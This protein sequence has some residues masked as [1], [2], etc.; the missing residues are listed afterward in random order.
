MPH[1]RVTYD[2][3]MSVS[4]ALD[5]PDED[6]AIEAAAGHAAEYLNAL[7][8]RSIGDARVGA[9]ADIDGLESRVEEI[10]P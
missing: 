4:V 10:A 8:Y 9:F 6:S 3:S 2:T 1:Y 5:A 7:T